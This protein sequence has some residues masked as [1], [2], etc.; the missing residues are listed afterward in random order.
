L[1]KVGPQW[2]RQELIP[3]TLSKIA[4][5]VAVIAVVQASEASEYSSSS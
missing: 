1:M 2:E 4:V 5:N 3:L